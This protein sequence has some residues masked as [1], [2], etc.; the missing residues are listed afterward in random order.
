LLARATAGDQLALER[1]LL[2]CHDRLVAQ[3]TGELPA[4]LRGV[5]SADDVL[6]EAYVVAFRQIGTFE[7]R[8]PDAFYKWLRA[9]AK[10]RLF[11]A[12]KAARAAKR[13]GGRARAEAPAG[14]AT[15]SVVELLDL[16]NLHDHTPSRS[17]AGH[18]AVAAVQVALASLKEDYREALRLRYID[19]LSVAETAARMNRTD[20]AVHMLC[21]RALQQLHEA[22]G[23]SSQ[24]F[25]R[26]Q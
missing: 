16:L 19:G 15:S 17:A 8:G 20:R 6:Q 7:P 10:N 2:G 11:D 5:V 9:I 24:Y 4:D 1:L 25:T 26:K 12:I 21:H 14:P 23:R 3:L 22:L 13:G 18:E